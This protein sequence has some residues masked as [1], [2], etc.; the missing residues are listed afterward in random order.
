MRERR[1]GKL[2]AI[3]IDF[4]TLKLP[5]LKTRENFVRL[6]ESSLEKKKE[7]CK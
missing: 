4:T 5:S 7:H 2:F 6:R 1:S 3:S